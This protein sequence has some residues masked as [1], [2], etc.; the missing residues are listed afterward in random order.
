M[1]AAAVMRHVHGHVARR[2]RVV[3]FENREIMC[4][5]VGRED[6]EPCSRTRGKI[7]TNSGARKPVTTRRPHGSDKS[8]ANL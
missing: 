2:G 6:G 3:S 7:Y 4:L 8:N 5:R 1:L